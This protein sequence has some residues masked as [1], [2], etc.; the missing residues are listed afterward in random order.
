MND[1]ELEALELCIQIGA[2]LESAAQARTDRE[3]DAEA[4]LRAIENKAKEVTM[5]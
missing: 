5:N 3:K 1:L 2:Q 4:Y